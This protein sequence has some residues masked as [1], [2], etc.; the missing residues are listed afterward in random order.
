MQKICNGKVSIF[1]IIVL[2]INFLKCG[3]LSELLV[4]T[5]FYL[6]FIFA[7]SCIDSCIKH[8]LNTSKWESTYNTVRILREPVKTYS[9][10]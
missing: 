2:I 8:L 1:Y 3:F 4:Q 10:F 6:C 7:F 9:C 5:K